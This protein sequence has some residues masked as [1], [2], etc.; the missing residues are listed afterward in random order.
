MSWPENYPESESEAKITPPQKA[1]ILEDVK[2]GFKLLGKNLLSYFLAIIGI[3]L[4]AVTIMLGIIVAVGIYMLWTVGLGETY[5]IVLWM[6]DV[7]T[8]TQG[9]SLVALVVFLI[10]PL[11]G[12]LFVALG[13]IYGLSREVVESSA[14]SA[15]SAFSWYRKRTFSL[16]GGGMV[17]FLVTLI[18]VIGAFLTLSYPLWSPPTDTELA[19]IL[20]L[21]CAWVLL[22]NGM[23]SMTFPGIIDGLSAVRAAGRSVKLTCWAPRRV[24]GVWGTYMLMIGGLLAPLVLGELYPGAI[25]IPE[26]SLAHYGQGALALILFIVL[27]A[28]TISLTR[29]YLILGA[30]YEDTYE[31]EKGAPEK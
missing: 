30:K 13:A 31:Y 12:P 4:L 5:G 16:I 24:L 28:L 23:L 10:A 3:I 8:V 7:I 27:P 29:V 21:L 14:T 22:I 20:L 18:P 25:P 11:L 9:M 2:H 6:I 19:L 26:E 17:H 15:S 1:G